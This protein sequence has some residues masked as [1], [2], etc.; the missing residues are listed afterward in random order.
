M[1]VDVLD[2]DGPSGSGTSPVSDADCGANG[3]SDS[4]ADRDAHDF[5]KKRRKK[6][7]QKTD[8]LVPEWT[9][10]QKLGVDPVVS[11]AVE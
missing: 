3:H 5:R 1:C 7:E 4:D 11:M 6:G 10:A 2:K 8:W 9:A